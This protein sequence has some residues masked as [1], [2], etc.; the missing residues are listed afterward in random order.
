MEGGDG[1]H[2]APRP[3]QQQGLSPV[4]PAHLSRFP[5]K[6]THGNSAPSAYMGMW[7]WWHRAACGRP[8]TICLALLQGWHLLLGLTQ[9]QGVTAIPMSP[10]FLA[11]TASSPSLS[12][13]L[14]H[15]KH[16][17]SQILSHWLLQKIYSTTVRNSQNKKCIHLRKLKEE[18]EKE[19]GNKG[20]RK[21]GREEGGRGGKEKEANKRR[22][23]KI[24]REKIRKE[25]A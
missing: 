18:R 16:L 10:P 1:H 6:E 4:W 21:E 25:T 8:V 24:E 11:H 7:V 15:N 13:L 19:K 22:K 2:G 23:R 20:K 17:S 12:Q 14:V 3:Q 5:Q 9:L